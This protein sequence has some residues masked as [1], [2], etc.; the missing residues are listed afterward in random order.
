MIYRQCENNNDNGDRA[1]AN[2]LVFSLNS[3]VIKRQE[4][5]ALEDN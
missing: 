5:V 3:K 1:A 4:K 2:E